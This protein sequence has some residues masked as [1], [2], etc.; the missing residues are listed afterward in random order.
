[1]ISYE[2][3]ILRYVHDPVT[4]EF[5]NVGVVLHAPQAR[6]LQA[7]L[8][9]NYGRVSKI[10]GHIDGSRYRVALRHLQARIDQYALQMP[11]L[12]LFQ[13]DVRLETMLSKFLPVDDSS[14]RFERG[15]AG[16]TDDPTRA[17]EKIFTRYVASN[18]AS[19][20]EGR[21][22]EEVWRTFRRPLDRLAVLRH[23]VPKLIATSDYGYEFEHAWKNGLWN[24]YE[25]ISFDLLD[26]FS[27]REKA[28]KW[29]G[30]ATCLQESNEKFKLVMLIG[31]PQRANMRDA[32]IHAENIL[33][34]IPVKKEIVRE[35][36]AEALATELSAQIQ[37][38]EALS[39]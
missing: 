37:E 10:F 28:N 16:I 20:T 11:Q 21:D 23:L 1:M 27:I 35:E 19:M 38:H 17:C 25:P 6:F 2:F 7:R 39:A 34:K 4:Q 8:N 24:L 32:F 12:D 3:S 29:L 22:R 14:L 30:R 26:E 15:G 13:G 36:E 9:T 5:A 18:E 33:N 31:A